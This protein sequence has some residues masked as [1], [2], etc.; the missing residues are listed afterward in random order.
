MGWE[1]SFFG[2]FILCNLYIVY[3]VFQDIGIRKREVQDEDIIGLSIVI[4]M[5]ILA[6]ISAIEVSSFYKSIMSQ[7]NK[8]IKESIDDIKGHQDE[9]LL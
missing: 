2:I 9:D 4:L 7:E 8:P 1:F 6:V 5:L 3:Q